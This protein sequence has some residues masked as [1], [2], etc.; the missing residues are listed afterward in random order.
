MAACTGPCRAD[1]S[2]HGAFPTGRAI[3]SELH[4]CAAPRSLC[5]ATS[6]KEPRGATR[7]DFLQ[8][9]H[10]ARGSLAEL[11][12]QSILAA[13][14]GMIARNLPIWSNS[15]ARVGQLLDRD[16][17]ASCGADAQATFGLL[18]CGRVR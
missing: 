17:S 11:E 6:Q 13:R 7:P 5:S 8:F 3:W 10:M 9:L 15:I 14:L 2:R 16:L 4:R 18:S 12:A 1:I